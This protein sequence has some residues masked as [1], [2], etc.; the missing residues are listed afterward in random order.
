MYKCHCV[1]YGYIEMA[2]KRSVL[3]EVYGCTLPSA[4]IL[5]HA[6]I[7]CVPCTGN[8]SFELQPQSTAGINTWQ[9]AATFLH[10]AEQR[11]ETHQ[12]KRFVVENRERGREGSTVRG[13]Q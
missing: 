10:T 2:C 6:R 9:A 12:A 3:L 5:E 13:W 8:C 11:H 4:Y 7:D 1:C